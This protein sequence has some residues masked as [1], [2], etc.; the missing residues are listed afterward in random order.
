[1]VPGTFK[2]RKPAQPKRF[3][4][5]IGLITCGRRMSLVLNMK[6]ELFKG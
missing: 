6:T 3:N 1:M 5:K 4:L 2:L